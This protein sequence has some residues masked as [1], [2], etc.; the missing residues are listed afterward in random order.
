MILKGIKENPKVVNSQDKLMR[1]PLHWACKRGYDQVV[2]ILVD[3]GA[4]VT[5]K[6]H[7]GRSC[8]D[9]AQEKQNIK[10]FKVSL[11]KFVMSFSF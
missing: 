11:I 9:I 7:I 4:D 3:F 8:K 5:I 10:V 6:D 2:E 1:T